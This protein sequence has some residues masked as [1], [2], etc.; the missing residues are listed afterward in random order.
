[1]RLVGLWQIILESSIG[2]WFISGALNCEI[3]GK[4]WWEM[5]PA[6]EQIQA[7]M[8]PFGRIKLSVMGTIQCPNL[9]AW[10]LLWACRKGRYCGLSFVCSVG[11]EKSEDFQWIAFW[12]PRELSEATFLLLFFISFFDSFGTRTKPYKG[13]GPGKRPAVMFRGFII[14]LASA[15]PT[16]DCVSFS[17]LFNLY[18]NSCLACDETCSLPARWA[19]CGMG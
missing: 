18:P 11:R 4:L 15:Q 17:E 9:G 13:I 19:V 2:S 16:G 1:M 3:K 7:V 10:A 5:H 12:H 14:C 8:K 6:L